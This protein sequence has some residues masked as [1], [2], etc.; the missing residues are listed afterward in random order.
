MNWVEIRRCGRGMFLM[1]NRLVSETSTNDLWV[2]ISSAVSW[3]KFAGNKYYK[4]D[5][6]RFMA[7][8][9][10][11]Q[12][13]INEGAVAY[14]GSGFDSWKTGTRALRLKSSAMRFPRR[15]RM[16]RRRIRTGLS[17]S[18]GINLRAIYGITICTSRRKMRSP[19]I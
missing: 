14:D 8:D 9:T 6:S 18:A 10:T 11:P 19:G 7:F 4:A 15:R 12:D 13:K 17:R 5:T 1:N 16:Y 3:Y 2:Q